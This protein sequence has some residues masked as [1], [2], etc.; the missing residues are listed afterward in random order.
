MTV[1]MTVP[2]SAH[3]TRLVA[4]TFRLDLIWSKIYRLIKKTLKVHP[5]AAS[6]TRARAGA[7]RGAAGT[8]A[9]NLHEYEP[10][11]RTSMSCCAQPM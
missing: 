4:C 7:R 2:Q 1:S 6:R 11:A 3:Q 8:R 9:C 10:F 5:A